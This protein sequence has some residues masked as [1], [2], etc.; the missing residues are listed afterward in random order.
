MQL[1]LLL[2]STDS[3]SSQRQFERHLRM[4]ALAEE[5]GFETIVASHH[6]LSYPY[7]YF[8]PIPLL[9]R[10]AAETSLRLATGVLLLPMLNPVEV[11]ESFATLDAVSGGRANFGVG[12]GY[13]PDEFRNLGVSHGHRGNRFEE[14]LRLILQLW[15]STESVDF[16]GEYYS[17]RDARMTM[18]PVQQPPPIWVAGMAD[19]AVQ[20][21]GRFGASWYVNP[22]ASLDTLTRQMSLY[23]EALGNAGHRPPPVLPIRREAFV[24]PDGTGEAARTRAAALVAERYR[25]Y[26]QWNIRSALP[27]SER[28]AHESARMGDGLPGE[29]RFVVGDPTEC[30]RT[31]ARIEAAVGMPTQVIVRVQWP[32]VSEDEIDTTIRLLGT[33]VL[34]LVNELTRH[35]GESPQRS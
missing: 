19:R 25:V 2:T 26:G 18:Q 33:E 29:G 6:F 20:R 16:D 11:A 15:S 27:P 31:L 35:S 3:D 23:R 17:L 10:L 5:S 7:A 21:A 1:G 4:V 24:T 34:P 8:Q 9:C 32:G 30:A 22:N 14:S 13:R 12:I 28:A